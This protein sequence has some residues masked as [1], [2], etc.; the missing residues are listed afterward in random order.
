M[1]HSTYIFIL[2]LS[3][4]LTGKHFQD[5]FSNPPTLG[6]CGEG[7][8]VGNNFPQTWQRGDESVLCVSE[9]K[10]I[11]LVWCLFRSSPANL[12][13]PSL[14]LSIA[15]FLVCVWKAFACKVCLETDSEFWIYMSV[16]ALREVCKKFGKFPTKMEFPTF[17]GGGGSARGWESSHLF[18]IIFFETFPVCVEV[19]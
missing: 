7:E 17:K 19:T 3:S 12:R 4:K 13:R 6:E 10:Y 9:E 16:E 2:R 5:S 15:F 11:V 1:L 8:V 18:L 14:D